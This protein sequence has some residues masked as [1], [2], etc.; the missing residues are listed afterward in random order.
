MHP[1]ARRSAWQSM[2]LFGL[3]GLLASVP[4]APPADTGMRP[5]AVTVPLVALLVSE[6]VYACFGLLR[7]DGGICLRPGNGYSLTWPLPLSF[8]IVVAVFAGPVVIKVFEQHARW[9]CSR[10]NAQRANNFSRCNR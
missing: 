10:T 1:K 3:A 7:A 6:G 2:I 4:F 5:Y 8:A 9:W